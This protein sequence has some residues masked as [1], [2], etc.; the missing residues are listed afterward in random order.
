MHV[1]IQI[2]AHDTLQGSAKE[3]STIKYSKAMHN[4]VNRLYKLIN[5]LQFT[6][7]TQITIA[8]S[9]ILYLYICTASL[10]QGHQVRVKHD[11]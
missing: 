1:E 5:K 2:S 3:Y 4:I 8:Y 7:Y 9:I 6:I 11:V 10:P